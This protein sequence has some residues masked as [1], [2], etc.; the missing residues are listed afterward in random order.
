[1]SSGRNYRASKRNFLPP[2][3]KALIVNSELKYSDGSR[4]WLM[5]KDWPPSQRPL[6]YK[7]WALF[8]SDQWD[9]KSFV[10]YVNFIKEDE[11]NLP[12]PGET[13]DLTR[14]DDIYTVLVINSLPSKRVCRTYILQNVTK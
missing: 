4:W 1:M 11:S 9:S 5:D 2:P 12:Q 13:I 10:G 8:D 3:T 6:R 7:N 14:G